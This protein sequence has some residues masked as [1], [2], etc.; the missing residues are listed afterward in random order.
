VEGRQKPGGTARRRKPIRPPDE[1]VIKKSIKTEQE[2]VAEESSK[3][4]GR[5]LKSGEGNHF[6]RKQYKLKDTGAPQPWDA[7]QRVTKKVKEYKENTEGLAEA[8]EKAPKAK[9]GCLGVA[10][11]AIGLPAL[12]AAVLEELIHLR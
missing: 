7:A 5:P 1:S 8:E 12:L 6:D 4:S 2:R 11:V 3:F 10:L 9:S